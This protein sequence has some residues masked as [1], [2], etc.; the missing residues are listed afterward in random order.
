MK[1]DRK[2]PD[3]LRM[4]RLINTVT[5]FYKKYKRIPFKR[6]MYGKYKEARELFGSWNQAVLK[7]GFKPNPV[8]F[9]HRYMAKDGHGCDSLTEKI[10]DDWLASRHIAHM[11][12]VPYPEGKRLTADFVV[13]KRWIEFFGLA[14]ELKEYDRLLRLK[15]RISDKYRLNLVELYPKHLFPRNHLHEI[16]KI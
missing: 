12:N 2:I 4:E 16:L 1:A 14:G 15:R 8:M 6:E 13:G 11:R 7:A 10:I 5:L 9:A 3:A